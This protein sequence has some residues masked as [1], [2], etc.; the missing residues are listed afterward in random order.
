MPLNQ[1]VI[2]L[3]KSAFALLRS[4]IYTRI[5]LS[6]RSLKQAKD[7]NQSDPEF[8]AEV[9]RVEDMRDLHESIL[10]DLEDARNISDTGKA[11]GR[12]IDLDGAS[13]VT[14]FTS[15][16]S[17]TTPST[18]GKSLNAAKDRLKV[19]EALASTLANSE[20]IPEMRAAL[21]R[22]RQ[23]HGLELEVINAYGKMT[24]L[25]KNQL[26]YWAKDV[27]SLERALEE[28]LASVEAD[29]VGFAASIT[30]AKVKLVPAHLHMLTNVVKDED[31]SNLKALEE[32]I[33]SAEDAIKRY[34]LVGFEDELAVAKKLHSKLIVCDKM[35]RADSLDKCKEALKLAQKMID[36][37][38][39]DDVVA[40]MVKAVQVWLLTTCCLLL[41]RIF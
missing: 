13:F 10:H 37:H 11:I 23:L 8:D 22:A 1:S 33:A 15:W 27:P 14:F 32:A 12:S 24:T 18:L 34:D 4:R 21:V 38:G 41:N 17:K 29:I 39:Q 26:G 5:K 28:A 7:L 25:H 30:Q 2:V 35:K 19:R 31:L 20:D 9:K 16:F 3:M 36:E 6:C 40:Q